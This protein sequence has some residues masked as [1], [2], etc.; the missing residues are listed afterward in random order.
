M[1]RCTRHRSINLNIE[2]FISPE[3]TDSAVRMYDKKANGEIKL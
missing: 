3:T 1:L 2:R